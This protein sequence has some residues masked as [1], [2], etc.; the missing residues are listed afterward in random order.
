[1][2]KMLNLDTWPRREHYEFF[3]NYDQPFF[4]VC[5][6]LD[7]TS[8]LEFTR[9]HQLSFFLSC[10]YL[11]TRAANQIDEFRYRLR[12]GGVVVHDVIHMGS[13]ILYDD[14]E[15]FGFCYWDYDQGFQPFYQVAEPKFKEARAGKRPLDP[16]DH[17][18]DL[19]HFTTLPW[20]HFSSFSHARRLIPVDSVPKIVFGQHRTKKWVTEMPVSVE[21]HHALMDGLHVGRWFEQFSS[22]LKEPEKVMG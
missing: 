17:R 16:A 9:E 4:N 2:S 11:A 19:I 12:D 3:R 10:L 14:R 7:V 15:T 8:T 18:D 22:M 21:V 6:K 1:M 20:I 13:T 5:A